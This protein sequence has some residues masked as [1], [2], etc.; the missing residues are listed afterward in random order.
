MNLRKIVHVSLT[1]EVKNKGNKIY[2]SY[3]LLTDPASDVKQTCK[4]KHVM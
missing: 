4:N 2:K 3:D 1:K